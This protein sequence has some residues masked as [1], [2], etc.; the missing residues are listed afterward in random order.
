MPGWFMQAV[1]LG[2]TMLHLG[3]G[4]GRGRGFAASWEL[5]RV[6]VAVMG[7]PSS[8]LGGVEGRHSCHRG[9]GSGWVCLGTG[10]RACFYVQAEAVRDT[11]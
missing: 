10:V 2:R 6:D 4:R 9:G 7:V 1:A 5:W 3:A 8:Q 11:I